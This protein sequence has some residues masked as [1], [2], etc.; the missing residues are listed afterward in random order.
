MT[1]RLRELEQENARL[2]EAAGQTRDE[3]LR[4]KQLEDENARLKAALEEELRR[5][6]GQEAALAG[7]FPALESGGQ[8][9]ADDLLATVDQSLEMRVEAMALFRVLDEDNDGLIQSADVAKGFAQQR[10]AVDALLVKANLQEACLSFEE[11]WGIVMQ[12]CLQGHVPDAT[13]RLLL[14]RLV[15]EEQVGAGRP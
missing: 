12:G 4:L 1:V 7:P 9:I 3:L 15:Q 6:G 14:E 8:E 2:R 11:F 13:E 5:A 10:A